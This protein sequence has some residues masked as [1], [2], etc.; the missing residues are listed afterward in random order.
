MNESRPPFYLITGLIIGLGLGLLIS[1]VLI[2]AQSAEGS[3]SQLT[4]ED[5]A[6][7]R[8]FAAQAFAVSND[9]DRAAARLAL[10]GEEN[11]S[12]QLAADAQRY[13][14]EGR[15][16]AEAEVLAR[17]ASAL[18]N[19]NSQGSTSGTQEAS[20]PLFTPDPDLATA[21]PAGD[22]PTQEDNAPT[23][24]PTNRPTPS[25]APTLGAPF[26]LDE[27]LV[28]CE[29]DKEPGLV[30]VEVQDHNGKPVPG[31][32]IDISWQDG[33]D[34]FFTGLIPSVDPGY[35]DYT[36]TSGF[37]Y[38]LRV[39]EVGEQVRGLSIPGCTA[40]DGSKYPGSIYLRFTQP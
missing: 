36:L 30:E 23:L 10:L 24:V 8:D 26:A 34:F 18:Q 31:I 37:E 17:L 38:T 35:A 6:I 5:K 28:I 40:N 14:A 29:A 3:P 15:S 27:R 19:M 4:E 39:G 9:L 13:L 25:P 12:N 1:L 22:T 21:V 33:A 16:L 7:Y 11:P 32:R 20:I 2:P